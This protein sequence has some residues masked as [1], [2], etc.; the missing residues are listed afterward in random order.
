M[1]K[2][3]CDLVGVWDEDDPCTQADVQRVWRPIRD[4]F[5]RWHS[6]DKFEMQAEKA[7]S[8]GTQLALAQ[9]PPARTSG[10]SPWAVEA[11][12]R[13]RRRSELSKARSLARSQAPMAQE[14]EAEAESSVAAQPPPQEGRSDMR[15]RGNLCQVARQA[16]TPPQDARQ[17][18]SDKDT[19]KSST[20]QGSTK[21]QKT[22]SQTEG[23]ASASGC[24]Q[25]PSP[26]HGLLGH[27][28]TLP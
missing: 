9:K 2:A 11:G 17:V 16:Q 3:F 18:P 13:L 12:M 10:P 23:K 21:R 24:A 6:Q 25:A 20:S 7:V 27:I 26:W 1:K 14:N 8:E 22:S 19:P 28:A 5:I 4:R 15:Q